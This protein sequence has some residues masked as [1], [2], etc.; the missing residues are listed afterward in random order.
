M[1]LTTLSKRFNS[2]I[3]ALLDRH[4]TIVTLNGEK[5]SGTLVGFN[6]STRDLCLANAVNS[7]GESFTRLIVY[8]H[9]ISIVY[10]KEVLLDLKEFAE[11]LEKHFPRMVK[12]YEEGRVI[13]VMDRIRITEHGVEGTGVM[14]E[15]I[16]RLFDVYLKEKGL[17]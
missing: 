14:A 6:P 4:I 5:Y 17:A 2:E 8:G 12:Y 7:E 10:T 13:T 16:K 1:S 15:R 11:I 3:Q 9:S